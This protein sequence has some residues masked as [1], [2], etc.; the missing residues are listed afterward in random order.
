MCLIHSHQ[1]EWLVSPGGL[2]W[3]SGTTARALSLP[4]LQFLWT[5]PSVE[6]LFS[7]ELVAERETDCSTPITCPCPQGFI[8][9]QSLG[10]NTSHCWSWDKKPHQAARLLTT[11][12][13]SFLERT[14][15]SVVCYMQHSQ[16]LTVGCAVFLRRRCHPLHHTGCFSGHCRVWF[17]ILL[18]FLMRLLCLLKM[19]LFGFLPQLK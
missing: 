10:A 3:H 1:F 19:C 18:I 2:F 14:C 6:Q 16:A 13:L 12:L 15:V 17:L 5:P 8:L 9:S 7:L 11:V 4:G